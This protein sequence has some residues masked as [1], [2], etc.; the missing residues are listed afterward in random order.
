MR[1]SPYCA[2]E[3]DDNNDNNG[4]F[5]DCP[6]E[7]DDPSLIL[8]DNKCFYATHDDSEGVVACYTFEPEED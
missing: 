7:F 4:L 6:D 2:L 8:A 1:V 5:Y 3:C